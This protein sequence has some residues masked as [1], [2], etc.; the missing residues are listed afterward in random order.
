MAA[1]SLDR[2]SASRPIIARSSSFILTRKA[3]HVQE[4]LE[5]YEGHRGGYQRQQAQP[6]EESGA[7]PEITE[8]RHHTARATETGRMIWL[9]FDTPIA[10]NPL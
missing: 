4:T 1:L 3:I 10:E 7:D 8:P 6:E 9:M 2:V 5:P